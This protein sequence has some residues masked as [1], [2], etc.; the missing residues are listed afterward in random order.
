MTGSAKRLIRD[1]REPL[2][3]DDIPDAYLRGKV[4]EYLRIYESCRLDTV[5]EE[6]FAFAKFGCRSR[7]RE[8][9]LSRIWIQVDELLEIGEI[10]QCRAR[11]KSQQTRVRLRL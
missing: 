10:E 3:S 7:N 11:Q 1:A 4:L 8:A 5:A 6:V 2:R 9:V